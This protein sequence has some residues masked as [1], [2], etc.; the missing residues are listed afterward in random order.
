MKSVNINIKPADDEEIL[1]KYYY[2]NKSKN[3]YLKKKYDIVNS[4]FVIK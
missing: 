1:N 2:F 4:I 3:Q